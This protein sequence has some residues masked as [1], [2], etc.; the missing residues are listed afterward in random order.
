MPELRFDEHT[1]VVLRRPLDAPKFTE[2]ELDELQERHLA[3]LDSLRDRGILVANGPFQDQDDEMLRGFCVFAVPLQEA[4][5]LM[6]GDPMVRV[7]RL[8][9]V[10]ATWLAPVGDVTFRS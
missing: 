2:E 3:Y 7:R 10:A 6:A 1:I 4:R 8:E 9:A 5:R